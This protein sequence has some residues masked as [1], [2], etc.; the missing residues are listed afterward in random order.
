M[1]RR[2]PA[3]I[4]AYWF[5]HLPLGCLQTVPTWVGS[6]LVLCFEG[7]GLSLCPLGPDDCSSCEAHLRSY[8][9]AFLPG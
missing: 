5:G 2:F 6:R 4:V 8:T 7:S 3:F 1:E 9:V